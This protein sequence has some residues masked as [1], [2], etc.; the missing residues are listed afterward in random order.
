MKRQWPDA[1]G[2]LYDPKL[3][4]MVKILFSNP[5]VLWSEVFGACTHRWSSGCDMVGD[6]V[7]D[8]A[9]AERCLHDGWIFCGETAVCCVVRDRACN[10]IEK[11][12]MKPFV[13]IYVV[14]SESLPCAKLTE[15][16][17]WWRKSVP[18]MGCLTSAMTNT[19]LKTRRRP[20]SRERERAKTL[21][22]CVGAIHC[23]EA[24]TSPSSAVSMG[25]R[26][27]THLSTSVYKE[28]EACSF[29]VHIKQTTRVQA[30]S[31]RHRC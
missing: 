12:D 18:R 1:G 8:R 3:Q 23:L 21:N 25:G 15:S 13:C 31:T 9:V 30:S 20:S 28:S 26:D 2:G 29:I 22:F 5:E 4:Y 16:S 27:Y 11:V 10:E 24:E 14:E 7:L 19:H 17:K 6:F